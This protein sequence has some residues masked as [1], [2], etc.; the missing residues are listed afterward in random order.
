MT[1]VDCTCYISVYVDGR[2][3]DDVVGNLLPSWR[4]FGGRVY[5]AHP[6]EKVER[7]VLAEVHGRPRFPL[8]HLLN[9]IRHV[10]VF[11]LPIKKQKQKTAL[12]VHTSLDPK[13]HLVLM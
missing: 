2:P 6:H 10:L 5:G 12:A 11:N 8:P 3:V 4:A 7:E 9:G 1:D 13:G